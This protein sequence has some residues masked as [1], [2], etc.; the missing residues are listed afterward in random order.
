MLYPF[1]ISIEK[2]VMSI[3]DGD[4]AARC[5]PEKCPQCLKGQMDSHGFYRRTVSDVEW[6]GEIRVRR[7]LCQACR[8]TVS[9]LPDFVLPY[10]RFTILLMRLFLMARL[11]SRQTWAAAADSG[12]QPE[13]PYQRGQQWVRRF[14]RRAESIA[15]ALAALVFPVEAV[16]FTAR[17]IG[18][19]EQ[20]GWIAA[21]RFLFS[22]L[23]MH[24]MGWPEFLA[25][26]GKPARSG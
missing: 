20:A 25:P 12:H 18:M 1:S 7:Y 16:D 13:M 21:H 15:A 10:W 23:R 8:R 5:R 11:V 4:Q 19:L 26:A 14:V 2:Y 9:L 3:A 24:L 6:N 22:Q 17:A